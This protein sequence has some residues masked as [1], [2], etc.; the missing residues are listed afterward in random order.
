MTHGL[1]VPI[2]T[3]GYRAGAT[4][5]VLLSFLRGY[6]ADGGTG[7]GQKDFFFLT[8]PLVILLESLILVKFFFFFFIILLQ[9]Y[10]TIYSRFFHI[11]TSVLFIFHFCILEPI[12][13]V[14]YAS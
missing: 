11:I 8:P 12:V 14:F 2:F 1:G 5:I 4:R 13:E 10:V 6:G 3:R 9:I 7:G